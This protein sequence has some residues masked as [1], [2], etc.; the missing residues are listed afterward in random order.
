MVLNTKVG[1]GTRRTLLFGQT[2]RR[3]NFEI[4]PQHSLLHKR[5]KISWNVGILEIPHGTLF[6]QVG[7]CED[8]VFLF[9]SLLL[10]RT[11][12]C[13]VLEYPSHVAVGVGVE[14]VQGDY[15]EHEGRRYYYAETTINKFDEDKNMERDYK[16]GE[17]PSAITEE[18]YIH[19]LW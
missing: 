13:V 1:R 16:I 8:T 7:D 14:G 4:R 15:Y 6:D 9:A 19:E 2:I 5:R 18:A 12:P 17:F 11:V 3:R 10:A